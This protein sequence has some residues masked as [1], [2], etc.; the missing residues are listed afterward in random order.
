MSTLKDQNGRGV[1]SRHCSRVIAT[2][3]KLSDGKVACNLGKVINLLIRVSASTYSKVLLNLIRFETF[4]ATTL[5]QDEC[6]CF[7]KTCLLTCDVEFYCHSP[8]CSCIEGMR[9][10]CQSERGTTLELPRHQQL[11]IKVVQLV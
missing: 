7:S 11:F 3:S 2:P 4:S 10:P 9:P 1:R 6:H 5:S 8:K